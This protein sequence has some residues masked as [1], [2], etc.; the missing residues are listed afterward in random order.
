MLLLAAATQPLHVMIP[1]DIDRDA[2]A[3]M[4][5]HQ[6]LTGWKVNF[7]TVPGDQLTED[8]LFALSTT[9]EAYDGWVVRTSA[10]PDLMATR[11]PADLQGFVT[12]DRD[13]NWADVSTYMRDADAWYG[14]QLVGL[15]I[16]SSSPTLVYRKDA[17]AAAGLGPPRTWDD[18][19]TAARALNGT[20][21]NRDGDG[22]FAVCMRLRGPCHDIS[23]TF[24]HVLSSIAQTDGRRQGWMFDPE[25][26][27]LLA[28]G[29]AG[30]A[31]WAVLQEL[32]ALAWDDASARNCSGVNSNANLLGGRCAVA[33]VPS[34][35][36][37]LVQ[38]HMLLKVRRLEHTAHC[39][40]HGYAHVE[41][42]G[43]FVE[44]GSAGG[45]MHRNGM[46]DSISSSSFSPTPDPTRAE[47]PGCGLR[48]VLARSA[49]P[50]TAS[51]VALGRPVSGRGPFV[52]HPFFEQLG[53]HIL[54]RTEFEGGGN[55]ERTAVQ[56]AVG[57]IATQLSASTAPLSC[58]LALSML[59]NVPIL[60]PIQIRP[61]RLPSSNNKQTVMGS[62]M[63]PGSLRVLNR[64]TGQLQECTAQL[65]PH[66]TFEQLYDGTLRLVNRAPLMD[67]GGVMPTSDCEE[68]LHVFA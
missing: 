52:S 33:I 7:D 5:E 29:A 22:D 24:G 31:A 64:A 57:C 4:E 17:F 44:M 40:E 53:R 25:T 60:K 15:P 35:E 3:V 63:T 50:L 62:V 10:I 66:A 20:D 21:F 43:R 19:L 42:G 30:Q 8:L 27:Q 14:D 36:W 58:N 38:Q 34:F 68:L 48:E 41:K 26:M 32:Q 45:G 61:S 59:P 12:Q 39:M 6:R 9:P 1:S 28:S 56:S 47:R 54:D 67:T 23:S 49:R 11:S 13:V 65:C 2:R 37:K 55:F 46:P 16:G 51:E 18:L